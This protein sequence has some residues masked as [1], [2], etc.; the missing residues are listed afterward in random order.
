MSST[1]KIYVGDVGTAFKV[2]V[3]PRGS[4][5]EGASEVALMVRKPGATTEEKWVGEVASVGGE[6]RA[7]LYVTQDGDL[8]VRGKY[9][10]QA[11]VSISGSTIRGETT[12]FT[13]YDHHK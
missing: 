11:L 13:V 2:V 12:R 6:N 4:N 10:V 8:D 1:S 7:V 5:I 9:S 3:A